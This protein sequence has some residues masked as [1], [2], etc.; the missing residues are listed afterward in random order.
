[1]SIQSRPDISF[2]VCQ[3]SNHLKEPNIDDLNWYNKTVKQLKTED[4]V[5]LVFNKIPDLDKGMKLLTYSD[6]S[7]GNLANNGS[8]CGYL[9]FLADANET[10]KNIISWK[11]VRLERVCSSTLTA[12]SLA[13]FKAVDHA[14]LIQQILKQLMGSVNAEIKIHCYVDNKGLLELINKTKDP[15]EKRLITTMA[16]IRESVDRQEIEVSFIPTKK[17]P[18]DVLTKKSASGLVLKSYLEME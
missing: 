15:T 10:V 13:L 5:P 18:A 9:I 17:M 6:A 8:Q 4:S 16:S 12:E 2:T 1:M 11:S 14:M 7:F 3:L